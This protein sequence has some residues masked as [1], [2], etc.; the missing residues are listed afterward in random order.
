MKTAALCVLLSLCY[1]RTSAQTHPFATTVALKKPEL[2]TD[3][4]QRMAWNTPLFSQLLEKEIGA[5]V[6][7]PIT[8]GFIF[9]GLVVS[10]SDAADTRSKTVVIKSTDRG[11]AALTITGIRGENGTYKYSGRMLSLKHSDAFELVEEGGLFA[12]EK[13]RLDELVSE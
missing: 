8:H 3:L 2:F 12:L 4:P 11:G 10:K 5:P 13:R 1:A 6:R 7:L 9:S